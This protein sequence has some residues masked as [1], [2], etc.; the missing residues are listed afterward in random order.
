MKFGSGVTSYIGYST[1]NINLIFYAKL[2]WQ[3]KT[4]SYIQ[5]NFPVELYRNATFR[6]IENKLLHP[7]VFMFTD[8]AFNFK[9]LS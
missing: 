2:K 7:F 5:V 4:V 1:I 6:Q 9:I 3:V 8:S